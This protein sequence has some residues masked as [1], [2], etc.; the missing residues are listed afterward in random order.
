MKQESKP[1]LSKEERQLY[2]LFT[3]LPVVVTFLIYT[4]L[5]SFY[6]FYYL[7]PSIRGDFFKSL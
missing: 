1:Y 6:I 2:K 5:L 4:I 3:F 7:R